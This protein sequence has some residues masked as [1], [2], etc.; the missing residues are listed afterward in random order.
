[1]NELK[2]TDRG[3][4]SVACAFLLRAPFVA[5]ADGEG[6]GGDGSFDAEAFGESAGEGGFAGADVADELKN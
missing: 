5:V 3:G 1:M 2:I 6:G 4:T